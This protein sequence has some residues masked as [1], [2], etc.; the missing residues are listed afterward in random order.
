MEEN[1]VMEMNQGIEKMS[2]NEDVKF[3]DLPA[4]ETESGGSGLLGKAVCLAVGVAIG[5]ATTVGAKMLAKRR[6]NKSK[7][8]YDA[9][10]SGEDGYFDGDDFDEPEG[11]AVIKVV[12]KED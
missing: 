5:A 11:D 10:E 2:E 3:Y 9:G 4:E 12:S 6:K 1:K 8:F 7:R